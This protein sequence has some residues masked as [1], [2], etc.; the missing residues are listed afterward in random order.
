VS[1]IEQLDFAEMRR[2]AELDA[3]QCEWT[4]LPPAPQP[5]QMP[6]YEKLALLAGL[7]PGTPVTCDEFVELMAAFSH[8]T[9]AKYRNRKKD[10][11]GWVWDLILKPTENRKRNRRQKMN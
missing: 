1:D 11:R 7:E 9:P 5:G 3:S 4:K 6:L 10:V 2:E 8:R